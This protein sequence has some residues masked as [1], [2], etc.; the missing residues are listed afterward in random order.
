MPHLTYLALQKPLSPACM[1]VFSAS[2]GEN[3]FPMLTTLNISGN[4]IGDAGLQFLVQG[5][6]M[7]ACQTRL[8]SLNLCF[9]KMGDEGMTGLASLV[10]A[11][12]FDLLI[13]FTLG[14]NADVTD[15]GVCTL[16][17]AVEDT[18]T[19]RITDA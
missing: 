13:D 10:G 15:E 9:A 7:P 2:L 16:A 14:W 19:T 17:Q 1:A 12:R 18:G 6:L 11:G 3:I 8:K 5:L 4:P